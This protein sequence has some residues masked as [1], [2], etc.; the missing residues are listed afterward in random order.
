MR[1]RVSA[2][3]RSVGECSAFNTS[4]AQIY[5]IRFSGSIG[6]HTAE[7]ADRL[8]CFRYNINTCTITNVRDGS[9]GGGGAS[10]RHHI[11]SVN[12]WLG[13]GE[14]RDGEFSEKRAGIEMISFVNLMR[15]FVDD[16]TAL[17]GGN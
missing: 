9:G 6:C 5:Y 17:G 11:A 8:N 10:E 14:M 1:V 3:K 4:I 15:L 7:S 12:G 2:Q 16:G 13:N